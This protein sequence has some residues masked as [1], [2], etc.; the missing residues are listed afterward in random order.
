[1]NVR[2]VETRNTDV[3]RMTT[4]ISICNSS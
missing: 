1:L 2:T 4:G 3:S